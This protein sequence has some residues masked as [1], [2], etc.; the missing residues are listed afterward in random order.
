MG[1]VGTGKV[2]VVTCK[3]TE[4]VVIF[5]EEVE[6]CRCTVVAVK[7]MVVVETCKHKEA[8]VTS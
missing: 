6:T 8:V 4:A 2:A 5:W 7:V 3:R 1:V